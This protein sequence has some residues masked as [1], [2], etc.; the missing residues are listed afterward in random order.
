MDKARPDQ[1]P[2][3]LIRK[4]ETQKP[5]S[6]LSRIHAAQSAD[7]V[8]AIMADSLRYAGASQKTRRTWDRAAEAKLKSFLSEPVTSEPAH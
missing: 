8:K 3:R 7:V 4:P 2:K 5:P 1:T 6:L